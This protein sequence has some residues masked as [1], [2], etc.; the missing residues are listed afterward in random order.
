MELFDQLIVVAA[1]ESPPHLVGLTGIKPGDIDGQLVDLVLKQDDAQGAFQRPFFQRMVVGHRLLFGAPQQILLNAAIDPDAGP[2]GGDFMRHV[3]QVPG[4]QP[5]NGLHLRRRFDLKDADGIAAAKHI[6]DGLVLEIDA[7]HIDSFAG[8][9][10]N[11]FN[12]FLQL[13]K[14]AQRQKIDFDKTGI[15][16]AVFI[17]LADI[18]AVDGAPDDG[19]DID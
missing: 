4:P 13:G 17:P 11:Q 5:G 3:Q 16:D 18:A 7:R 10:F 8:A 12:R 9:F 15:V 6:V 1:A 19:H 2:D 14:R